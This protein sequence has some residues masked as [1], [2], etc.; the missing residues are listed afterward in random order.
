MTDRQFFALREQA[1]R[2]GPAHTALD[3]EYL[4]HV[5]TGDSWWVVA[6]RNPRQ[7]ALR[8]ELDHP[9]YIPGT[10]GRLSIWRQS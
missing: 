2:V 7:A 5:E 3:D 8:V 10:M 6:A 1:T 4:V 9:E